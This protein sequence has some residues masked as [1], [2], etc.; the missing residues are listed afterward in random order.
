MTASA[1]L[2]LTES[3]NPITN[4]NAAAIMRIEPKKK[5]EHAPKT[6][7]E[8]VSVRVG[9]LCTLLWIAVEIIFCRARNT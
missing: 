7:A 8:F 1:W 3:K 9:S 4:I 6:F 2:N 5:H